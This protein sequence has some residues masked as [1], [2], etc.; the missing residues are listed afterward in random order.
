VRVGRSQT[1]K[2][3]YLFS[4]FKITSESCPHRLGALKRSPDLAGNV[5]E[6]R[7][8]ITD[9]DR[10]AA[11]KRRMRRASKT[12]RISFSNTTAINAAMQNLTHK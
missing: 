5:I 8:F 6:Y 4:G 12:L 7:S 1:R 10:D 11:V 2:D 9:T 3:K